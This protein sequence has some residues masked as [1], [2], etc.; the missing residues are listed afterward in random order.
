MLIL[1]RLFDPNIIDNG[2]LDTLTLLNMPTPRVITVIMISINKNWR[3]LS[4]H[5]NMHAY[6]H[7]LLADYY[8][9]K[10]TFNKIRELLNFVD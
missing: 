3:A 9:I 7:I 8:A 6:I 1:M 2:A 4:Y 10:K 5:R